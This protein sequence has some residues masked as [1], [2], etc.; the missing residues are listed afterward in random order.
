MD[1][2]PV[3]SL[4]D[5]LTD[6]INIIQTIRDQTTFSGDETFIFY[7]RQW[8]T[9]RAEL[10]CCPRVSVTQKKVIESLLLLLTLSH[11]L[12]HISNALS[13]FCALCSSGVR[14]FNEYPHGC[15]LSLVSSLPKILQYIIYYRYTRESQRQYKFHRNTY[16]NVM[17]CD[18]YYYCY[19]NIQ[20]LRNTPRLSWKRLFSL[21]QTGYLLFFFFVQNK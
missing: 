19:Y 2:S 16:V 3:K 21:C 5:S 18:Y 15:V 10:L 14:Y 12:R 6:V 4:Y 8:T 17:L 13:V 1:N 11:H 7:S 9:W 20:I